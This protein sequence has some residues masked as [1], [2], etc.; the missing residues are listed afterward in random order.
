MS[1]WR[2]LDTTGLA[3][4]AEGEARS[5]PTELHME[6]S[7][8]TG[9]MRG[10]AE[11]RGVG[12]IREE[13]ISGEE[14][15]RGE[16]EIRGEEDIRGEEEIRVEEEARGEEMRG[17]FTEVGEDSREVGVGEGLEEDPAAESS[18]SGRVRG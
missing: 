9:E 7:L 10:A 11:T 1:V 16:V 5:D 15:T 18:S 8:M 6:T 3:R 17:D 14:E 12:E 13:V 4:M 2:G